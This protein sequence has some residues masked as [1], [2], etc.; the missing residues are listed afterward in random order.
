M[1]KI[2]AFLAALAL[3]LGACGSD[4]D[5]ST[6]A[7]T[8]A[9][10]EA[11]GGAS[12]DN[13]DEGAS[14]DSDDDSDADTDTDTDTDDQARLDAAIDEIDAAAVALGYTT[15]RSPADDDDADDADDTDLT[16]ESEECQE[17]DEVFNRLDEEFPETAASES[18]DANRGE[19]TAPD[20]EIEQLNVELS[21]FSSSDDV[22]AAFEA[23]QS[24][25]LADCMREA[26]SSESG[27]EFAVAVESV[28]VT[29]G[30]R[31]DREVVISI[32]A[33]FSGGG[34]EIAADLLFTFVGVDRHAAFFS[35]LAFN[36]SPSPDA[37]SLLDATVE[38]LQ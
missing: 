34:F 5:N 20:S 1:K 2:L 4:D 28:D 19:F 15:E 16:F 31:G 6:T 37:L 8:T 12:D 10:T 7:D 26:L 35:A 17:A 38:A 36:S 18:L 29:E 14:D 32:Q 30:G 21:S 22:A 23:L 24:V 9:D 11:D 13:A 3:F 25:P 27:D 33:T